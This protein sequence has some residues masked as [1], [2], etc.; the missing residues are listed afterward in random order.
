MCFYRNFIKR[1]K[2]PIM[3]APVTVVRLQGRE[4]TMYRLHRGLINSRKASPCFPEGSSSKAAQSV[5]NF[6]Q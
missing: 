1:T 6:V 4:R 2:V 5:R 3:L